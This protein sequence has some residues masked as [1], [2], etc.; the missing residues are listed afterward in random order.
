M[1][2][3]EEKQRIWEQESYR[4]EV[5]RQLEAEK[6]APTL[7]RKL[8]TF[9]NSP[10]GIWILATL[11]VGGVSWGYIKWE[12]ARS[13]RD[14]FRSVIVKLDAEIE[15]RL[16]YAYDML[17]RETVRNSDFN[18][19]LYGSTMGIFEEFKSRDT[20]SL[21]LELG[22]LVPQS[23]RTA[24]KH[25]ARGMDKLIPLRIDVP[26]DIGSPVDTETVQRARA[27]LK[28]RVVM[29]RWSVLNE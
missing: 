27:I 23:E 24:V 28:S 22:H 11:L 8:W 6:P 1:I 7:R 2:S 9:L 13:E 10:V 20:R 4:F 25:A 21:I 3:D 26:Y 19:V 5:R 12:A 18:N 14:A 15:S 16:R 17:S 29:S